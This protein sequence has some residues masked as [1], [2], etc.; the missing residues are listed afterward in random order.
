MTS[1]CASDTMHLL[2]SSANTAAII[3]DMCSGVCRVFRGVSCHQNM[4]P[5]LLKST[6]LEWI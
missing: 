4:L 1:V 6:V 2:P 3:S 5:W